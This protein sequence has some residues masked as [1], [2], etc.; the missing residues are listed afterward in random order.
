MGT[1]WKE[2][3]RLRAWALYNNGWKQTDIAEALGVTDGAVSQWISAA[4]NDGVEALHARKHP[5][6]TPKINAEQEKQLATLLKQSATDH[7]YRGAVWTTPRVCDLIKRTFG[8]SYHPDHVG[9]ILHRLGFSVQKPHLRSR[10]R[11]DAAVA[12]WNNTRWPALKKKP[13]ATAPQ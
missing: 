7:G 8:I 4:R 6:P 11:D 12:E 1:D 3:R 5:G 13:V 9:R 2:Q 10:Q